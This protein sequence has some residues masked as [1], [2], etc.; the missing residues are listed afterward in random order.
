MTLTN[1]ICPAGSDI[2]WGNSADPTNWTACTATKAHTL[3]AGDGTKTVYVRWRS[4]AGAITTNL[5]KTILLDTT[6]PTG[7]SF[8]VN[9]GAASTSGTAVT[10]TTT[11]ATDA[12]V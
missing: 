10:L 8:M 5:T 1:I 3:S 11:C 4:A 12:G 7:G 2:A 6:A 9:A